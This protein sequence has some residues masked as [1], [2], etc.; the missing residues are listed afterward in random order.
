M[1]SKL[2]VFNLK[3]EAEQAESEEGLLE[4]LMTVLE[5]LGKEVVG[6]LTHEE[7]EDS[8]G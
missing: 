8:D 5:N 3:I 1:K 4:T 7:V 6:E 2:A